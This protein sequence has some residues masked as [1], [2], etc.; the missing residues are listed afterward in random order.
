MW[1]VSDSIPS[2]FFIGWV[3]ASTNSSGHLQTT[4]K[5]RR[6]LKWYVNEGN[7]KKITGDDSWHDK[8]HEENETFNLISYTSS[9]LIGEHRT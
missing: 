7:P 3:E 2:E 5:K 9:L 4:L 6:R 1:I 8:K